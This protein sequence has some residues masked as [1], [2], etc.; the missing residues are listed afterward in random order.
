M[1]KSRS[2]INLKH[3]KRAGGKHSAGDLE[4]TTTD[5]SRKEEWHKGVGVETR[6]GELGKEMRRW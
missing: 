1:L 2:L 4:I 6:E 3:R 5:S